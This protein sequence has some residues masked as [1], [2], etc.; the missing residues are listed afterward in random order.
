[1]YF[2]IRNTMGCSMRT[3]H[4]MFFE[5]PLAINRSAICIEPT[6]IFL[7]WVKN[8]PVDELELT[9]DDLRRD[10]MTYLI[11]E[12]EDEPDA[13]LRRNFKTIFEIELGEW[14][15]DESL[16]PKD[17]SFKAFKKYFIVHFCSSVVDLDKGAI[18]RESL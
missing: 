8:F 2:E 7:A 4:E 11:P 10:E 6:A 9:L 13:W 3:R 5:N 16:W 17:R 15:T 1:M 18:E 12:Q 14:C